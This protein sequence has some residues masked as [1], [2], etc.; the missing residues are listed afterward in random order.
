VIHGDDD[1]TVPEY[2]GRRIFDAAPEPK[3]YVSFPG[4]G[5]S[6]ISSEMVVPAITQFIDGV[7]GR[8]ARPILSEGLA[9]G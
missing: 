1:Q 8:P 6:D 3:T 2:M 5:H 4:G 7:L 9:A